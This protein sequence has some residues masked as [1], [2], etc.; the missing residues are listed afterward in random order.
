MAMAQLSIGGLGLSTPPA[1]LVDKEI[2][3]GRLME[4]LPEWTVDPIDLFAVRPDTATENPN[5]RRLVGYLT[6]DGDP[7]DQ[8]RATSPR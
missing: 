5:T 4:I 8:A 1:F 7:P 2:A 6:M 3:A